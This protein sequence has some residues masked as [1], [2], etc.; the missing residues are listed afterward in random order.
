M[1]FIFKIA[2]FFYLSIIKSLQLFS[3]MYLLPVS[4][5]VGVW[6]FIS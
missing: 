2:H 5:V 1:H 6:I 4:N 3:N